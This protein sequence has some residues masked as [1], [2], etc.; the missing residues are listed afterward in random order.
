MK[1]KTN[2][3]K[4]RI[5]NVSKEKE[6][7]KKKKSKQL[8]FSKIKKQK[9]RERKRKKMGSKQIFWKEHPKW[10]KIFYS[11]ISIPSI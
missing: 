5:L 2:T 6:R 9:R 1:L 3:K 10:K 7:K 4:N 11:A 8:R